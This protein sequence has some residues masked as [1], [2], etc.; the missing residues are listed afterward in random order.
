DVL[1]TGGTAL[2]VCKLVERL[3]GTVV[4]CNF[5]IELGSLKGADNLKGI[6]IK[7]L[8]KY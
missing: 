8:L 1:A 6:P 7:A 4:Q 5:L 2:A 3:G